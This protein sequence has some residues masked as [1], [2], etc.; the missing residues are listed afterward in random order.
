MEL[1]RELNDGSEEQLAII[2]EGGYFG[3]LGPML[4]MPRS[5]SARAV[6]NCSLTGYSV[7]LFRSMRP[8]S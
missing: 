5:A 3:E 2:A 8:A 6:G 7:Q 1:F 4:N